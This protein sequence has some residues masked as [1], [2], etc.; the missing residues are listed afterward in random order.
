MQG[1][2]GR[3]M[4]AARLV[5]PHRFCIVTVPVPEPASD[6]VLVRVVACGVC[7]GDYNKWN[8][9]SDHYPRADGSPGHE[10]YGVVEKLGGEVDHL[11][12]GDVVT[13]IRFPGK[14]YAEFAVASA[15]HVARVPQRMGGE[16]VLGEPLACAMNALGR[17]G[18]R[19]GD[20]VVVVGAGFMGTLLLKMLAAAGIAPLVAA[21]LSAA[22]RALAARHGADLVVDPADAGS[23]ERIRELV[24]AE[25]ADCVIEATGTQ[26]ALDFCTEAVRV[27]GT[28]VVYGYHPEGLRTINM[29]QWNWKGLDVVNAHE[30]DP[31]AYFAGMTRALRLLEHGRIDFDLV[32]HR[33][34]L[35]EINDC[36]RLIAER[37]PDYVKAVIE[38]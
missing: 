18:V 2:S 13:C 26:S 37:P 25:G 19:P 24:G 10:V 7:R 8:G 35:E 36:F 29:Q 34:G 27:R 23:Q 12:I 21:E 4:K 14:G 31:D 5:E 6:E 3:L 33:F 11:G 22:A 16:I 28:L 1:S 38:P 20:S 17:S 15:R 30:R 9:L 32:S